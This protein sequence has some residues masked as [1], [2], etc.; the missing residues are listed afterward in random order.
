[1]TFTLE[2]N[3]LQNSYMVVCFVSFGTKSLF[4][5]RKFVHNINGNPNSPQVNTLFFPNLYKVH[6]MYILMDFYLVLSKGVYPRSSQP[7]GHSAKCPSL[8]PSLS[9]IGCGAPLTVSK[10]ESPLQ[11]EQTCCFQPNYHL[12][13]WLRDN[14]HPLLV[15][16][17]QN[18][19]QSECN[20]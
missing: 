11:T 17:I 4:D 14:K 6:N 9:G 20:I 13:G 8:S 16:D 10:K 19:R 15:L 12:Q 7:K 2:A 18:S 1:M 5:R 3:N